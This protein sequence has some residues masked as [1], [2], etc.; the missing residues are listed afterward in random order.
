MD[1]TPNSEISCVYRVSSKL[2]ALYLSILDKTHLYDCALNV[3]SLVQIFLLTT[4][5]Q[6]KVFDVQQH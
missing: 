3:Q 6:L 2:G 4:S 5:E 1:V